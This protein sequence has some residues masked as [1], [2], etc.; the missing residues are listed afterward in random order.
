[1]LCL[2]TQLKQKIRGRRFIKKE[3]YSTVDETHCI[4]AHSTFKP[5]SLKN[6][7]RSI[8]LVKQANS[9]I[10]EKKTAAT[11][12]EFDSR[13]NFQLQLLRKTDYS[14]STKLKSGDASAAM[15]ESSIASFRLKLRPEPT[16]A[17]N[18]LVLWGPS[19]SSSH[20]KKV[21]TPASTP[22]KR[23]KRKK[24]RRKGVEL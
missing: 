4:T 24:Q 14:S 6:Q 19:P 1:M 16:N 12:E 17:R 9:S 18:A 7:A 22:T 20:S 21:G 10:G 15:E 5:K 23:K 8:E 11:A 13:H 3:D 2:Q